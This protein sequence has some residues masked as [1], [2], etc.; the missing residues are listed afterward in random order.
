MQ[1]LIPAIY[2][3]NF[4]LLN[5]LTKKHVIMGKAVSRSERNISTLKRSESDS[6]KSPSTVESEECAICLEEVEVGKRTLTLSC[7]HVYHIACIVEWLDVDSSCPL[8]RRHPF[9]TPD[10]SKRTRR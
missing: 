7:G 8:C 5:I 4:D 6:L 2:Y 10:H 9:R 3:H 1:E